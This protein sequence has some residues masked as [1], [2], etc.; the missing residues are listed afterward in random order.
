MLSKFLSNV[1]CTIPITGFIPVKE[2]GD[3]WMSNYCKLWD[4]SCFGILR[5]SVFRIDLRIRPKI[6]RKSPNLPNIH[7][8]QTTDCR[9]LVNPPKITARMDSLYV[10]KDMHTTLRQPEVPLKYI[11]LFFGS[12]IMRKWHDFSYLTNR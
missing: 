5:R 6:G 8:S 3:G 7:I 10:S 11:S 9:E 4:S 1:L 12:L 2:G